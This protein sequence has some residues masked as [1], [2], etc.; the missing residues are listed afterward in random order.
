MIAALAFGIDITRCR[1]ALGTCQLV[2]TSLQGLEFLPGLAFPCK[3]EVTVQRVAARLDVARRNS[4]GFIEAELV[5]VDDEQSFSIAE[6]GRA[7]GRR[8]PP[9][10]LK[11]Q[12]YRGAF[13]P[14]RSARSGVARV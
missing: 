8:Q 12:R 7:V 5:S 6:R 13:W 11:R 9:S 3:L 14:A 1:I 4:A 2:A 10:P